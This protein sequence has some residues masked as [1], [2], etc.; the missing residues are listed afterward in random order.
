MTIGTTFFGDKCP[1]NTI[2]PA[3][4]HINNLPSQTLQLIH[5]ISLSNGY[6]LYRNL[7][8]LHN[9]LD[10]RVQSMM[11]FINNVINTQINF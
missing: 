3:N 8:N 10:F 4:R 1:G 9:F 2:D 5:H 7:I 11:Y 6:N